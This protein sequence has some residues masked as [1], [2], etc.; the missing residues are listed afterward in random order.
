MDMG[1]EAFADRTTWL[2]SACDICFP[3]C[4]QEIHISGVIRAI[5]EVAVGAGYSTVLR[6]AEVNQQTCV[7]CGLCVEVCPYEAVTLVETA[8][9]GRGREVT[10]A[11]VDATLCMACGLCAASCRST[12]IG[13]PDDCSNEA[14]VEELWGWLE[15]SE[16][17]HTAVAEVTA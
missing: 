16:P 7:A 2:C 17:T 10:V 8:V 11:S 1:E 6:T 14:L 4:P 15:G 9:M 3:A 13:L 5:R 12:S